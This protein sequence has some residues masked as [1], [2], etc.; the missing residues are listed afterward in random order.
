MAECYA[1]K[2]GVSSSVESNYIG[3]WGQYGSFPVTCFLNDP[4][5][6]RST[7]PLLA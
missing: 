5:M 6:N 7:I 3:G 4:Q 2:R 1:T